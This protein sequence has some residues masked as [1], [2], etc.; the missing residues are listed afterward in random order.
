MCAVYDVTRRSTFEAINHWL[1]EVDQ[2]T[3][4]P[5]VILLLVGNQVD[6]SPREVTREEGLAFA[7]KKQMLFIECSAKTKVG[8]QQTFDGIFNSYYLLTIVQS[9]WRR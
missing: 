7:K 9:S 8:I 3:T 1:E 5:D 6:K 2:H 4:N